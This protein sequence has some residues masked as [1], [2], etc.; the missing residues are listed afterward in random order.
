MG[1]R[2][3]KS[4]LLRDYI[5]NPNWKRP[6]SSERVLYARSIEGFAYWR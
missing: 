2:W 4:T 6:N 5:R 1:M 3:T